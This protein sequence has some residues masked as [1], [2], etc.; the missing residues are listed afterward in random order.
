MKD[1]VIYGAGGLGKEIVWLIENI[2]HE[3][4]KWNILGFLVDDEYI[5]QYKSIV[6]GFAV[7]PANEWLNTYHS[8]I[9][10]ICGI[11]K[12]SIRKKI[13]DKLSKFSHVRFATLID[14]T[15]RV[16]STVSIGEGTIVCRNCTITVDTIIGRGVL[17]NTGASV[18]HDSEIGDYC[19]LLTNSIIAGHT[20]VGKC[21]EIGSGAFV[22]QGKSIVSNT[23]IAPLSSILKDITESGTYVGNPA[24]RMM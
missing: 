11:G 8:E 17:M 22:L 1:I 9:Y 5:E 12:S 2:N 19:T 14:P 20:N 15:V 24:R 16:D 4:R 10:V 13:Y 7:F 21:C 23:V 3:K 6:R 18:G